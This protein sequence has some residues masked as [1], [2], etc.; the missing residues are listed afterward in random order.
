M[1][2]RAHLS[3]LDGC[4][5]DVR[6]ACSCETAYRLT[7][8]PP[9]DRQLG[10]VASRIVCRRCRQR[11]A[12]IHLREAYPNGGRASTAFSYQLFPPQLQ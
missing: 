8:N 7:R 11:P 3:E 12:T 2:Y 5:L 6:C 9:K 4:Y 1:I 10:E